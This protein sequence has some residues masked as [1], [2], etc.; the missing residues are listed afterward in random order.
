MS[1]VRCRPLGQS[2]DKIRLAP[3][4]DAVAPIRRNIWYVE[5]AERRFE[6]KPAAE[7]RL[8]ILARNRMATGAAA[9]DEHGA[10]VAEVGLMRSERAGGDRLG[11]RQQPERNAAQHREND[12]G[13]DELAQ[14]A[15]S[16]RNVAARQFFCTY[17][18]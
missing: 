2:G 14:H 16:L 15:A 6:R 1:P 17:F 3:P 5:R 8:V 10:A 12:D 4:A 7:P 13:N 18:S 9:R 11:N